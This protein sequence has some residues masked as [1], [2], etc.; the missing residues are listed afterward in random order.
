M[1]VCELGIQDQRLDQL[2]NRLLPLQFD[3]EQLEQFAVLDRLRL[4]RS[5]LKNPGIQFIDQR[6][7]PSIIRTGCR[8]ALLLERPRPVSYAF[9][10]DR[11]V[12]VTLLAM[13]LDRR[14]DHLYLRI[15]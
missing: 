11:Q 10:N 2:G 8:L 13:L 14:S 3:H 5:T 6:V 15:I 9:F 7:N 1:A 4:T 12:A